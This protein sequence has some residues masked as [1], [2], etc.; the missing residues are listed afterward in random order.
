MNPSNKHCS[1]SGDPHT[2]FIFFVSH[3]HLIGQPRLEPNFYDTINVDKLSL[4]LPDGQGLFHP[5][6]ASLLRDRDDTQI[7]LELVGDHLFAHPGH[8]VGLLSKQ[9]L[10]IYHEQR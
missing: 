9:L 10:E 3:Q 1:G 7:N 8:I 5:Q 6:L 4:F 2:S